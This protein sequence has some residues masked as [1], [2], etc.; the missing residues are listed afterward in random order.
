MPD[1]SQ[2]EMTRMFEYIGGCISSLKLYRAAADLLGSTSYFL[3]RQRD[4]FKFLP[5]ANDA[6]KKTKNILR[7]VAYDDDDDVL[8]LDITEV[9]PGVTFSLDMIV[10]AT[11]VATA[12]G[13]YGDDVTVTPQVAL[14]PTG[15][16]N[17]TAPTGTPGSPQRVEIRIVASAIRV[18][19]D[20]TGETE[21]EQLIESVALEANRVSAQNLRHLPGIAGENLFDVA[22]NRI[23]IERL[24]RNFIGPKIG[25]S[26]QEIFTENQV[27][28][29]NGDVA[30]APTGLL[31]ELDRIMKTNT[32]A[33]TVQKSVITLGA[34][35]F[36]S[37][38]DDTAFDSIS[39]TPKQPSNG[40]IRLT[41]KRGFE[42]SD[43]EPEEFEVAFD[44]TDFNR[45]LISSF[46]LRPFRTFDWIE[47]GFYFSDLTRFVELTDSSGQ[48][49]NVTVSNISAA[50]LPQAK[51]KVD[52]SRI[53]GTSKTFVFKVISTFDQVVFESPVDDADTGGAKSYTLFNGMKV[54]F[55][56]TLDPG[57]DGLNGTFTVEV[58]PFH[59]GDVISID[60]TSDS[61]GRLNREL[62][63]MFGFALSQTSVS[64]TIPDS[65]VI[66]DLPFIELEVGT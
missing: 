34:A 9:T 10:G 65:V 7:G 52:W 50:S 1:F 19:S 40:K 45:T 51:L 56:W 12:T 49:S 66:P 24:M 37:T 63:R 47:G 20:L 23:F 58:H 32:P 31:P 60:V 16:I 62:Q 15:T 36:S 5:D 17:L 42:G 61:A 43:L 22:L 59:I 26:T 39:T 35:V 6:F 44:S 54:S 33:Q 4:E 2:A 14:G 18:I 30:A 13:S 28:T 21:R 3:F 48:A 29:P 25:S 64:P 46:R 38:A 11:T 55:D 53:D 27:L 41:C 57:Q 8:R